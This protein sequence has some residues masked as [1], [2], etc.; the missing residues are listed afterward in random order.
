MKNTTGPKGPTNVWN[1]VKQGCFGDPL[2]GQWPKFDLV[3]SFGDRHQQWKVIPDSISPSTGLTSGPV[4]RGPSRHFCS[5][6]SFQ[7]KR[8][9]SFVLSLQFSF[10]FHKK[11][12]LGKPKMVDLPC[13]NL[14]LIIWAGA[15]D[16]IQELPCVLR[17][18]KQ[19]K[20]A[21]VQN[22]TS[23]RNEVAGK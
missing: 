7:G 16:V 15:D 18:K 6:Y 4:P 10:F 2:L 14:N 13:L 17:K 9:N 23:P 20:T 12:F 11:L 22:N 1:P 19:E 5:F 21:S 3:G 8:Q